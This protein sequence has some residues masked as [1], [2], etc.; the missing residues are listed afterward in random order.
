VALVRQD[1]SD[2]T[3]AEA[4]YRIRGELVAEGFDISEADS[5]REQV[6]LSGSAVP[7]SRVIATIDLSV[8]RGTH[9]AELRVVD[10]LTNKIVVRRTRVDDSDTPHTAE[11]LAVRAVELLR[12]SLLELLLEADRPAPSSPASVEAHHASQWAA[13]ALPAV[14]ESDWGVEVGACVLADFGGVPPVVL[15]LVRV[16]RILFGPLSARVSMAGLGTQS[17]VEAA[18]GSASV[19]QNVGLIELVAAPWQ[20]AIVHPI[21]SIGVGT[22]YASVDGQANTP[23]AGLQSARWAAAVDG[24]VGAET[25][26][27]RHF[28]LSLEAHALIAQP[29]PV[30]E[31]LGDDIARCGQPSVVGSLSVVGWL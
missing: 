10:R 29:Y 14:P 16:R 31:F 20:S 28:A 17:R 13:R 26:M 12:A 21:L 4:L 23:Y 15:G 7:K 8:D 19:T 9:I 2:P 5:P 3:I 27:G 6:P 1:G 18:A 24:G 30:V 25:K 22:F 11:L